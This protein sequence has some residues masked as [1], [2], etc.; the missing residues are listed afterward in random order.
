[1]VDPAELNFLEPSDSPKHIGKLD[2]YEIVEKSAQG[3]M[4][5][6]L[7]AEDPL[8]RRIVA[9]KV[10]HPN[11]ATEPKARERFLREARAAAAIDHE[12]VMPI[13][14][15]SRH[16]N[17]PY[18]VMPFVEGDTVG[19][20]IERDGA[21]TEEQIRRIGIQIA[22][23]LAVAHERGL[24]H[25]DI[26]PANILLHPDG[27]SLISDFGLAQSLDKGKGSQS[28][29]TTGTPHFMSPEQVEGQ[30]VDH[31]SDLFSLGALMSYMATGQLPFAGENVLSTLRKVAEEDP[32]GST[33][34]LATLPPWL[35]KTVQ[36]LM[37]KA[38]D[39]RIQ[40]ASDLVRLLEKG[41]TPP[42]RESTTSKTL[43]RCLLGA[44]IA[45]ALGFV[46]PFI[47]HTFFPDPGEHIY[48]GEQSNRGYDS[49]AA[50]VAGSSP[51]ETIWLNFS[52]PRDESPI[53]L[54]PHGLAI[55][56]WKGHHP[57]LSF[58]DIARPALE[59][60]DSLWL[61]GISFLCTDQ[62]L[63][64]PPVL[65]LKA[66]SVVINNCSFVREGQ[67]AVNRTT[68]RVSVPT[69][70]AA[71]NCPR[72]RIRN[73]L[74][75]S[76]GFSAVH[77]RSSESVELDTKIENSTL[78]SRW[79]ANIDLAQGS[80]GTLEFQSCLTMGRRSVVFDRTI[81]PQAITVV[82]RNSSFD[83]NRYILTWD[84]R[85]AGENLGGFRWIGE[86]NAYSASNKNQHLARP[87]PR[88][89]RTQPIRTIEAWTTFFG[90]NEKN[91][92]LG[93]IISREAIL[94]MIDPDSEIDP[95]SDLISSLAPLEERNDVGPDPK[96]LGPGSSLEAW[97]ESPDY[98]KWVD[99][100]LAALAE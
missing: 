61:E 34:L 62:T 42:T 2:Q 51:R 41:E 50:A 31:R 49:L 94:S 57:Q 28:G 87:M 5:I 59:G 75:K 3:A 81:R 85:T 6:V 53:T 37:A 58:R 63:K 78:L 79:G 16:E 12:N 97:R 45:I 35:A 29:N 9:I 14:D 22:R 55:R 18:F 43:R 70:I 23:G 1:M 36:L 99:E 84:D 32:S 92:T 15:V 80:S 77:L 17:I 19:Q 65:D 39:D 67:Q 74:F 24:I 38:P 69:T 27:R 30:E 86:N 20:R 56:A 76:L 8:L 82:A 60:T 7:K 73:T 88:P 48:W 47:K 46:L 40:S 89:E 21:F 71:E 96:L 44:A 83:A 91:P 93:N 54:P 52:G 95:V 26:K 33:S 68:L 64:V 100:A 4:G 11:L 90:E 10:L 66:G 72:I 13:F 25:R 98:Q